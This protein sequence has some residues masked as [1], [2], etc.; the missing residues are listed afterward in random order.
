[1]EAWPV[2]ARAEHAHRDLVTAGNPAA[3][4][5]RV[6]VDATSCFGSGSCTGI[7]AGHFTLDGLVS[8]PTNELIDPDERVLDAAELC[9]ATAIRVHDAA[10]GDR[11]APDGD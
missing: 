8:R 7:A 6:E 2:R 10:T 4:R 5:W 3:G 9:P 1:M 11:L